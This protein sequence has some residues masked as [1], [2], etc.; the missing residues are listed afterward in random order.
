MNVPS[1]D[2]CSGT[3]ASRTRTHAEVRLAA[4]AAAAAA[5]VAAVDAG[6]AKLPGGAALDACRC[7][8]HA[9]DCLHRRHQGLLRG[10]GL[11]GAALSYA[12]L[13]NALRRKRCQSLLLPDASHASGTCKRS[14]LAQDVYFPSV[15][16]P[17][18]WQLTGTVCEGQG[19]FGIYHLVKICCSPVRLAS[20]MPT[21]PPWY[22]PALPPGP[23][24]G[25]PLGADNCLVHIDCTD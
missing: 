3:R 17:V 24:V 7:G 5:A 12:S 23:H 8:R 13:F 25:K 16:R 20:H 14:L 1:P 4:G 10:A 9:G 11:S 22:R 19:A 21:S 6:R 18:G 2:S 15:R